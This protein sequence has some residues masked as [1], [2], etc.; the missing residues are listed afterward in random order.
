[1]SITKR[2]PTS[3]VRKIEEKQEKTEKEERIAHVMAL[4][5]QGWKELCKQRKN[6]PGIMPHRE[7]ATREELLGTGK[8]T[9]PSRNKE[10]RQ[11]GGG[12][13]DDDAFTIQ[14]IV[15]D[16]V[17]QSPLKKKS[18]AATRT[19]GNKKSLFDVTNGEE[20]RVALDLR[21]EK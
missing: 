12:G 8:L 3:V 14:S 20:D 19:P 4:D 16:E 1:M 15:E 11:G 9:S 5:V 2:K 17:C 21:K 18:T 13:N 10:T 7:E 6:K